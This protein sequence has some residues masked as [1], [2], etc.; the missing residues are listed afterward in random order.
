[1]EKGL[2]LLVFFFMVQD[3]DDDDD[4]GGDDS[5]LTELALYLACS[6]LTE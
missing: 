5:V 4:D 2:V 6:F 3:V 1:M